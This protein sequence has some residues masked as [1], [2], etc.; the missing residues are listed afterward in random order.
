MRWWWV[1]LTAIQLAC[2]TAAPT[3]DAPDPITPPPAPAPV[4]RA[5]AVRARA[6]PFDVAACAPVLAATPLTRETFAALLEAERPRFEQCLAPA[7]SR[8]AS[9][10][11]A[12]LSVVASAR[13]VRVTVTP[14]ALSDEAVAC[15]EARGAALAVSAT[16]ELQAGLTIDAPVGSS[17]PEAAVV[18][19][20]EVLR[21]RLSE[22]CAC[23][24]AIGLNAPPQLVVTSRPGAPLDVV[25]AADVIAGRVE[26]CLEETVP[27]MDGAL[28][29]TID[30]PLLNGDAN[31]PSL[32]AS[33]D[34]VA[35]QD[36][37]M[38]RRHV[39]A[40]QLLLARRSALER[41]LKG[42]AT[43]LK[44]K[45]TPTLLKQRASLCRQ[46]FAVEEEA[47]GRAQLATEAVARAKGPPSSVPP[48]TLEPLQV[49]SAVKPTE[50]E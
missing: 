36:Q 44:R 50:D 39:A 33:A 1:G 19:E 3:P 34:V 6:T 49:C 15:L 14:R 2:K 38:A 28:E 20:A 29:V 48:V 40:L 10:A 32:D 26:R 46:L 47:S 41:Q 16:M 21:R 23:F 5:N 9:Q 8:T 22:A 11:S 30:L 37:A 31:Q 27:G 45:A 12:E 4:A 25:T 17:D 7:A 18:P 13:G 43:S 24:T 42:V 35:A